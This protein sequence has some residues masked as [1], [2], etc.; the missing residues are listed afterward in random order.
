MSGL[1]NLPPR[2]NKTGDSLLAKKASTSKP[3]TAGIKLKGGTSL[4]DRISTIVALVEQKLGKYKDKYICIRDEEELADYIKACLKTGKVAIDTE[5]ASTDGS[6]G[7]PDPITCKIV[8]F[9]LYT[10]GR[11]AAYIPIHHVSY[12]TGV[13]VDNQISEEFISQQL[14]LL[15][16]NGVKTYWFN[17]KYDIRVISNQL[18]VYFIPYY[19]AY[20]GARLLNENEPNNQLKPLHQKYVLNGEGDAWTFGDLFRGIPFSHIPIKSAYLYAARDGE[21]T[22]ELSEFQLQYLD[23]EQIPEDRDDLRGVADVLWH[24]EMPLVPVTA[25]MEDTGIAFDHEYAQQLSVKYNEMLEKSLGE[26]NNILSRYETQ[27][28]EYIRK[29]KNPKIQ[30]PVNIASPTQLAIL[31]YDILGIK[32]VDKKN[33][34]GTG[35]E[36]L[37]KI[38]HPL[39]KAILDYR[40]ISKL[41]STYIDKMPNVV[42]KK[43]GRI[44]ASF[45]QNGTDTGRFSSSDPNMQNIPSHNTDIRKMFIPSP[46]YVFIGADYSA[47]E[48]RITSHLSNDEKMIEAYRQGKDLYVEIASLAFNLPYDECKEFRADGTKNP[49]GKERRNQAKAIVLGICYG[50]GVPAIGED[51][52]ITTQK[53]QEVY[54]KVMK[55]FPGL[56]KF[57]EDSELMAKELGYVTT[58]WGRKRRLPNIQLPEYEYSWAGNAPANFDPLSFGDNSYSDEVPWDTQEKY[59]R[60]L[61]RTRSYREKE[62]IKQK[63]LAEGIKIKDN[64]ALIAEATRQC[65]NSRVQG[66]AADMTKIAMIL[67]GNNKRLQELGL[68]LILPVHDELIA[69]CPIENVK[70]VAPLYSKLMVEAASSLKVPFKCDVEITDR[71][72]GYVIVENI[73]DGTFWKRISL[74]E[75]ERGVKMATLQSWDTGQTIHITEKTFN[76]CYRDIE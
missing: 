14:Q 9:S 74:K 33:P 62:T 13:E 34:R 26:F 16:D 48:P 5:T 72:Y 1:F 58:A 63:A 24:I 2:S 42:N 10:P 32:S 50:K 31:L 52:G 7:I 69:E 21:I 49:E 37:E 39:S 12:V 28:M 65:V 22:F 76:E 8:G 61:K 56:K 75:D 18:G 55:A 64:G 41:I 45:N 25:K 4:I 35:E 71:W 30:Y 59:N 3:S 38:D 70:E 11:K 47:Q 53:A 67:I 20:I 29:S 54:D 23:Y 19:D 6:S 17:A 43:T 46:G 27:I 36:I 15:V 57:M 51:L 40:G 68:R 60:L 66:S 44:H 73:Q